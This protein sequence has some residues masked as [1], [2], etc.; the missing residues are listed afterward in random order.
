MESSTLLLL[1][2]GGLFVYA[3]YDYVRNFLTKCPRCKGSGVLHSDNWPGRYR[4]CSRCGRKG[5]VR[6]KFGPKG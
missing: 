3:A 4:P 5:E 2:V 1:G 6:H